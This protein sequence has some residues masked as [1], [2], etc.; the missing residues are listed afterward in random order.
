MLQF[1]RKISSSWVMR[2]I[3]GLLLLSF[4]LFGGIGDIFRSRNYDNIVA[5][6]GG[7]DIPKAYLL[8]AVQN[9]IKELNAELKGKNLSFRQFDQ[10][11]GIQ[12]VLDRIILEQTLERFIQDS[13]VVTSEAF[14]KQILRQ[15]QAFWGDDKRFSAKKFAQVLQSNGISEKL[16]LS[17]I[18]QTQ[19]R[20]QV[21]SALSLAGG[22]PAQLALRMYG[23]FTMNRQFS[24]LEKLPISIAKD[25]EKI[26]RYYAENLEIFKIPERRQIS[27]IFLNPSEI[28]KRYRFSQV[29]MKAFYENNKANY[30][31]PE[32]RTVLVV[33]SS[34]QGQAESMQKKLSQKEK[35]PVGSF[36]IL[37]SVAEKDLKEPL[38]SMFFSA[39]PQKVSQPVALRGQYLVF[40]VQG[41][42]QARALSFSQAQGQILEEMR[43]EKALEEM[44]RLTQSVENQ[45]NKS[46]STVEE[47]SKNLGLVLYVGEI[48]QKGQCLSGRLPQ[49]SDEMTKDA[50]SLSQ[51]E[52]TSFTETDEGGF[53]ILKVKDIKAAHTPA[54]EEIKDQVAS[55]W[56]KFEK[57]QKEQAFYR[58]LKEKSDKTGASLQTVSAQAKKYGPF[59]PIAYDEKKAPFSPEI[60]REVLDLQENESRVVKTKGGYALVRLDALQALPVEKNLGI[61]KGFKEMVAKSVSQSLLKQFFDCLKE[62]YDVE[63]HQQVV[64]SVREMG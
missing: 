13:G 12:K 21:M 56:L 60:A 30:I 22:A 50:F 41:I 63:V 1:L 14:V 43:R 40:Q 19:N 27:M 48:D 25:E 10:F 32:K 11:I 36:E 8:Q 4:V 31:E 34:D 64:Q 28:G 7:V 59:S 57:D 44:A 5:S 26:R 42:Q 16:F 9:Q 3:L 53:Y 38:R 23:Y 49:I 17:N 54:Y 62:K 37:K 45:L 24:V 58:S 52:E 61:Y 33:L 46:F 29:D 2:V 6:V 20:A 51:G 39:P 55:G 47:V 15:E 35:L 18:Q